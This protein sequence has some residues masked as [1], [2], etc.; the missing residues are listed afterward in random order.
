MQNIFIIMLNEPGHLL[1]SYT[2]ARKLKNTG[3]YNIIYISKKEFENNIINQGFIF[4]EE[5]SYDNISFQHLYEITRKPK[6]II[7]SYRWLFSNV[8][9]QFHKKIVSYY[10]KLVLKYQPRA[11][12][13]D[14]LL[15]DYM[16]AF[17]EYKI[18]IITVSTYLFSHKDNKVPPPNSTR[19]PRP[20]LINKLLIQKEWNLLFLRRLVSKF[21][22]KILFPG[23]DYYRRSFSRYVNY[24]HKERITFKKAYWI[25]EKH[26]DT[27]VL[28]PKYF[29]FPREVKNNV[30]YIESCVN[31]SRTEQKFDWNAIKNHNPIV[32]C[33]LG[34][35]AHKYVPKCD[36]FY[37]KII[38]AFK[39]R[40]NY[41]L[42][43]SIGKT[44]TIE[45]LGD[46]PSNVYVYER[47]PQIEILK[48][49]VLAI[50]HG[51]LGTIKECILHAVPILV[52]PANMHSDQNGNASR[53]VYHKIG[54]KGNLRKDNQVSINAAIDK[55]LSNKELKQNMVKMQMKF[56]NFEK[57]EP[58]MNLFHT[59]LNT[60]SS[61]VEKTEAN[62]TNYFEE[63]LQL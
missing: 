8:R 51:G 6:S 10:K 32:F 16:I 26:N 7:N 31:L 19:T 22:L 58:F 44:T 5:F 60:S 1:P 45:K 33:S 41:N 35:Q 52:Y 56:L 21:Y 37:R 55:M 57:R 25:G 17:Y 61:I 2:I 9:E 62:E 34:T 59:K 48:K 20:G 63:V 15:V 29:D 12:F 11:I 36:V 47:V 54:I 50:I 3:L 24:P 30:Y 23:G 39:I 18:P 4:E 53:V 40:K 49:S 13:V 42:I 46:L 38:E 28:C 14:D 43:L 27:I